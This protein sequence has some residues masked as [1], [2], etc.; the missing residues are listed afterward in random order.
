MSKSPILAVLM[1][2][3]LLTACPFEPRCWETATCPILEDASTAEDAAVA[4]TALAATASVTGGA[5]TAS[6]A[7]DAGAANDAQSAQ[8]SATQDG[9]T[10]PIS[11]GTAPDGATSNSATSNGTASASAMPDATT[12]PVN[13][14]GNGVIDDGERCDD[15]ND[16]PG[17]G[18]NA[19]CRFEKGWDCGLSEPTECAPE[20]G[21]G[22]LI[23]AEA[24]AGG[25]DDENSES[26]DGCNSQC[27]VEAGYACSGEPSVC[28]ET[29][30]DGLLDD[31]EECDDGNSVLDDGC[32]A[33][34][35]ATGFDC[36][37]AVTPSACSD[38]DECATPSACG[39][40]EICDN[41][42]GSFTCA[43]GPGFV[44]E[45][46][47]CE[48]MSCAGLAV[49]C[50]TSA[51]SCCTSLE[52]TGGSFDLGDPAASAATIA[53]F[54]LDKYEVTVGRFRKFVEA[55]SGPPAA[56][57]GA[58]PLIAGSGWQSAWDANIAA[59]GAAL[60][61]AVQCNSTFQTWSTSGA[62]DRLPMNCV[63][64][65][66]AFAFC[67][68]DG[69]R[70]PTEAEWEYAAAGG[71]EERTYPWGS[72]APTSTRAMYGY[73]GNYTF[74]DLLPAGSKPTGA[75][76]YGQMDLAGSM[77]EWNL[78]QYSAYAPIC[79]NCAKL[80]GGFDR[81]IRGGDFANG[82]EQIVAAYRSQNDPTTSY[83]G[84]GFRCA[85]DL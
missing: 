73:S 45:P 16:A 67:A 19:T 15:G 55:Y 82:A 56:G 2:S 83:S 57:A 36:D 71:D 69:G 51:D 33:C 54:K 11:S 65:Y 24:E 68:W 64:W 40:H 28:A 26:S 43:C 6:V 47:A 12:A 70:L 8:A 66:Q 35:A 37:V 77:M 75:G 42:P 80:T 84:M 7:V 79:N 61:T 27:K 20:C 76:K 21:D 1:L 17:D 3:P 23:G 38:V 34:A 85:R 25:C 50:G 5:T 4:N 78:D 60:T 18:C 48:Q 74:S 13:E 10:A 22:L 63:S 31:G 46:G 14:C 62:N 39:E 49:T 81:V 72:A 58:H 59:N 52:V 44:G 32:V 9:A 29:C 41:T 30:G 53:T